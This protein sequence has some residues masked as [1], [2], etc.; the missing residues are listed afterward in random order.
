MASRTARYEVQAL[1]AERRM[2]MQ[3]RDMPRWPPMQL[4]FSRLPQLE[5][6]LA[7]ALAA[8]EV[9]EEHPELAPYIPPG[10][11]D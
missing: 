8:I 3:N 1:L 7:Q 2:A 11:L 9:L 5:A 6:D 10:G 4:V